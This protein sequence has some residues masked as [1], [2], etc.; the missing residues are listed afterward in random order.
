[1]GSQDK[2]FLSPP[3]VREEGR[4]GDERRAVSLPLPLACSTND[5]S[6]QTNFEPLFQ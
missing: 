4:D 1:M 5:E 3:Q 2:V 6:V